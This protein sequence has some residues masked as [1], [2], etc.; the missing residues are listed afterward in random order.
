[1]DAQYLQPG[2]AHYKKRKRDDPRRRS[3]ANNDQGVEEPGDYS[4]EEGKQSSG[5]Y[6]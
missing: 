6:A 1:M 2:G 5:S 3:W 4:G